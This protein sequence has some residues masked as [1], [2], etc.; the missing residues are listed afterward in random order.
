MIMEHSDAIKK[1]ASQTRYTEYELRQLFRVYATMV[2]EALVSGQDVHING[3]GKLINKLCKPKK[4]R[5]PK[6]GEAITIPAKRRIRFK[7][8]TSLE[9]AMRAAGN[10]L[11]EDP[12]ARFG[13]KEKDDG[14]V[15]RRV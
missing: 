8:C 2:R 13:L 9:M 14:K 1:L 10:P 11:K 5:N 7:A 15:R 6:T 4:G 12:L 3:I